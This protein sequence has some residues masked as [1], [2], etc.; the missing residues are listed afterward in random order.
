MLTK[1][2]QLRVKK[3]SLQS[4]VT[5]PFVAQIFLAVSLTGWMAIRSGQEAVNT[6]ALELREMSSEQI[7][8]HLDEYLNAPDYLYTINKDFLLENV[9]DLKNA[10]DLEERFMQQAAFFHV[11]YIGFGTPNGQLI[12]V[13]RTDSG[14]LLIHEVKGDDSSKLLVYEVDDKGGKG[15]L[16]YQENFNPKDTPW[17]EGALISNKPYWRDIY[18]WS[19][20]PQSL[21]F[22]SS[23]PIYNDQ[24]KLL[25]ILDIEILLSQLNNFLNSIKPSVATTVFIVDQFGNLIASSSSESAVRM[26]NGK[27]DRLNILHSVD[28]LTRE[29]AKVLDKKHGGSSWINKAQNLDFHYEKERYWIHTTPWNDSHGLRWSVVMVMPESDFMSAI[30]ANQRNTIVLCLGALF[31]SGTIGFFTANTLVQSLRK[32]VS[33][34]NGLSQGNWSQDVPESSI[35]EMSLLAQAFN[36]MAEQLQMSFQQ[37]E[38]QANYDSLTGLLNRNSFF[39]KLKVS[40]QERDRQ[41]VTKHKR[42]NKNIPDKVTFAV[43]FLDLDYF[44]T[45]NDSLGHLLGDQLLIEVATRLKQNV[46]SH[47]IVARF[48]GDEF[49]ILLNVFNEEEA[50]LSAKRIGDAIQA[51]FTVQ[52]HEI[53]MSTSIGIVLGNLNSQV[54]ENFIQGADIALYRAKANGKSCYALFDQ[55]MHEEAIDRLKLET[56]LEYVIS[57]QELETFYQPI[58]DLKTNE[59]VGFEALIRW[60]HPKDGLISPG[61]F[62][63]VAEETGLAVDI[64]WWVLEDAC[65][66]LMIWQQEMPWCQSMVMSVNMTAKQ[67]FQSNLVEQ[68]EDVIARTSLSPHCLKLEIMENAFMKY[69]DSVR[70]KLKRIRNLGIQLSIDDFGT[71]YSSLSYLHRFPVNTLKIDRS[72]IT[73][74]TKNSEQVDIVD[75]ITVLAHRLNLNVIAE[76][77]ETIEQMEKLQCLDCDYG[78]GFLFSRPISAKKMTGLLRKGS[79]IQFKRSP[80]LIINH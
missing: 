6:L 76:G 61:R 5:V 59:I 11:G 71:G 36:R 66:Q 79:Q 23:Y 31:I 14:E 55:T 7:S 17:Y 73:P 21:T 25:G 29:M 50:L 9:F 43:L 47:D 34:A 33:V 69:E 68:L 70:F 51:P 53:F 48:G 72:F 1:L 40:I 78:Q 49:M 26:V 8:R 20:R 22:S 74:I 52:G 60:N 44:K 16:K 38:R 42:S 19:D 32:M 58:V 28:P 2:N 54:P 18:Q 45:V 4:I 13:E 37:L 75:A 10:P 27:V 24:N 65:T 57:R 63:P 56:D 12:G 15:R 39:K 62:I 46:R 67:F 35:E 77:I 41:R 30:Y 80:N 64:G 3:W